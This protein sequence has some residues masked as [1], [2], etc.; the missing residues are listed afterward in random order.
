MGLFFFFMIYLDSIVE[1]KK[2]DVT[3]AGTMTGWAA[4]HLGS[5]FLRRWVVGASLR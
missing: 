2:G 4:T 1:G 5:P 3:E